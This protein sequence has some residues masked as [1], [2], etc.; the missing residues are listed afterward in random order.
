M[1]S[2]EDLLISHGYKLPKHTTTSTP[3][4]APTAS[5]SCR[6]PSCL[7]PSYSKHHEILENRHPPQTVN[8]YEMGHM[9]AYGNSSSSRNLQGYDGGMSG[10]LTINNVNRERSQPTQERDTRNQTDLLTS[11]S[12]YRGDMYPQIQ[13]APDGSRWFTRHPAGS[14]PVPQRERST[15][16]QKP[17]NPMYTSQEHS[18]GGIQYIPFDDTRIRHLSPA[19]GGSSLTDADKI[20]QFRNELPCAAV[21]KLA[22]NDSAFLPPPLGPFITPKLA[23]DANPMSSCNNDNNRCYSSLHKESVDNFPAHDQNCNNRCPPKQ[24]PPL[25]PSLAFQATLPKCGFHHGSISDP[26]SADTI[27]HVKQI[28]PDAASDSYRNT[29]RRVSETIFCLVSVPVHTPTNIKKDLAADQNNNDT[30]SNL[31]ISNSAQHFAVCLKEGLNIRSKSVNEMPIKS[32]HSH[33]YNS[34]TLSMKNYKRAPL[35]KEIIDAWARQANEDKRI[36]STVSW[37]GNQYRNQETQTGSPISVVKSP[38]PQSPPVDQDPVQSASDTNTDNGVALSC[39]SSYGYPMT[40]QKN[41]NPSSNS[42]FSRLSLTQSSSLQ[43]LADLSSPSNGNDLEAHQP[44]SPG[45]SNVR[46]PPSD[47]QEAFGQFLLRPVNRRPCDA[48]DVLENINKVMEDTISKRP[49]VTYSLDDID[50]MKKRRVLNKS[51]SHYSVVLEPGRGA[52]SLPP[53]HTEKHNVKERSKSFNSTTDF[54]SLTMSAFPKP[55]STST[56]SEGE[57]SMLS[58]SRNLNI[59]DLLQDPQQK[60]SDYLSRQDIPVPQESLLRDVGLT[61]YTETLDASEEAKHCVPSTTNSRNLNQLDQLSTGPKEAL[62]EF[63]GPEYISS[64]DCEAKKMREMIK[65]SDTSIAPSDKG[66]YKAGSE[67]I[68]SHLTNN[69]SNLK[70]QGSSIFEDNN[71]DKN[72]ITSEPLTFRNESAL[73]DQHLENLLI[74]DQAN[75][76]PTEDLSNLYEVKCAEG[77]PENE[78]IEARAARILGIDVAI[79]VLGGAD[80]EADYSAGIEGNQ[81]QCPSEETTQVIKEYEQVRDK[82]KG[83]NAEKFETESVENHKG[84]DNDGTQK[85]SSVHSDCKD[86]QNAEPQSN[87]DLPEFPSGELPL[88]LSVIPQNKTEQN[89]NNQEKEVQGGQNNLI[90]SSQVKDSLSPSSS[91]LHVEKSTTQEMGQLKA[92][93]SESQTVYFCLKG[94]ES[95]DQQEENKVKDN[96][97]EQITDRQENVNEDDDKTDNCLENCKPDIQNEGVQKEGSHLENVEKINKVIALMRDNQESIGVDVKLK[98]KEAH[99]EGDLNN[100]EKNQEKSLDRGKDEQKM[101]GGCRAPRRRDTDVGNTPKPKQ[102]TRLPKPPLLPK[103]RSVPKRDFKCAVSLTTGTCA[104]S[105]MVDDKRL[106]VSDYYDPSQVEQV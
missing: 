87:L 55:Q 46:S 58:K 86:K 6:P 64:K 95:V 11:D 35:R 57:V 8:G 23:N 67:S 91:T 29:K 83:E 19:L 94:Q 36:C 18:C 51:G 78:S 7:P 42:A 52:I 44:S 77:I 69:S 40:G 34:S 61:V 106:S 62:V 41:L 105:N 74:F 82:V 54:G 71:S 17:H 22:H 3:N 100:L 13:V 50:G 65:K 16:S 31:T 72:H 80:K 101:G 89:I 93:D 24:C 47:D 59:C 10:C 25:R 28:A 103:P 38:E 33:L 73:A 32:P 21:S 27:T 92:L 45:K 102:R 43:P 60:E 1:Y 99:R 4:A 85:Q 97:K 76:L 90:E 96:K 2:V 66:F 98:T 81:S 79:E 14:W 63:G 30:V 12:G 68:S 5:T 56:K 49:I 104:P 26:F 48:I 37:P 39:S 88:S 70:S 15:S 20:L 84:N 53:M 75:A 9:V